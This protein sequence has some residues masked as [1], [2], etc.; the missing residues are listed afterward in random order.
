MYDRQKELE[1]EWWYH[2]NAKCDYIAELKKEHKDEGTAEDYDFVDDEYNSMTNEEI[3]E[4]NKQWSKYG[5][6]L[7]LKK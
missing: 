4:Y 7:P 5:L 1:E 2:Y 3:I 6:G